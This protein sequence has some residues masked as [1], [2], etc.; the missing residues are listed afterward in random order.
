MRPCGEIVHSLKAATPPKATAGAILAALHKVIKELL[1]EAAMPVSCV[2]GIGVA[3]PGVVDSS[4]RVVITPNIS[5][6]GTELKKILIKTYRMRAAVGNDVNFGVMG[7][8]WLGAGRRADSIVGI[9]PGTGVGG[10]II[11]GGHLLEGAQG[12]AAELGHVIV[13]PKGPKCTCGNSGCLEALAGRWAMERDIRAAVKGG[14][15][16][17]IADIAGKGL[18]QIKSGALKKALQAKDPLV[19]RVV[20]KAAEALASACVSFNHIFNPEVFIFGGGVIEACGDYILPVIEKAL[21]H[22]PFF[23]KLNPPKVLASKLG[24]DAVMLGAVAMVR[25]QC[26]LKE[27]KDL[28]YYPKVQIVSAGRVRVKGEVLSGAFYIRA[29]GKVKVPGDLIPS[30]LTDDELDD[31]CKKGPDVLI[32][33]CGHKKSAEFSAMALKYLRKKKILPCVLPMRDAVRKYNISQ[34]RRAILFHI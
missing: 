13:H 3:V 20:R 6:S 23:T 25:Q 32:V 16:S 30:H 2:L 29:D 26:D 34:D 18:S 5:L 7:E 11:V 12:A 4:G 19:T 15:A 8:R 24:D 33:A 17:L 14:E 27:L 21:Q 10:G 31:I 28:S 1:K 9:F 22:D